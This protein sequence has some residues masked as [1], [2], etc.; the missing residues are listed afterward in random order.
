MGSKLDIN[1]API[2][3]ANVRECSDDYDDR[4]RGDIPPDATISPSEVYTF[5]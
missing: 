5:K 2:E 3:T 1:S 4:R